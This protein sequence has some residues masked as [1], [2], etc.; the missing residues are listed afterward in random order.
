MTYA[1]TGDLLYKQDN[2]KLN[3]LK[4]CKSNIIKLGTASGNSHT[5]RGGKMYQDKNNN[6]FIVA[7]DKTYCEHQEHKAIKLPKGKYRVEVVREFDYDLMESREVV[8]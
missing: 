8:D 6:M 2:F 4:L 1:Q 5:L 7:D 3:G